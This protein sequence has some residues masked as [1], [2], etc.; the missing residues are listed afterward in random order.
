MKRHEHRFVAMGGPCRLRLDCIDEQLAQ[1]ACTAAEAEVRRLESK[2]SR[3]LENSITSKINHAAGTG[4]PIAIDDE[5]SRLLDYAD[6]LFRESD[7][8][9][10]LTSGILRQ[11]WDFQSGK[12]P[13]PDEIDVLLSR[14][15][16]DKV[17]RTDSSVALP[18]Q[19]MEIDFGGCVK[20]YASDSAA[21]VLA[22]H[23]I[24]HALVDLAGDIAALNG[25]FE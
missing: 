15:G 20:E 4:T 24:K 7:G 8:L 12:V 25:Q 6:T 5:T 19:G 14:I 3:Y 18:T 22:M 11:A 16:W 17:T 10:D 1:Q 2:Y 23:G 9:F 13:A 21:A